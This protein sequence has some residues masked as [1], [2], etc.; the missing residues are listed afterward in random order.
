MI[1]KLSKIIFLFL[2]FFDFIL[3]KIF[4]K[5]FLVWFKDF[6]EQKSYK[7]VNLKKDKD[8][9]KLTFFTPNYLTTWLV[10]DFFRKEPETIEWIENFEKKNDKIIFWDVGANIGL[11]SI[12]AAKI[13]KSIEVISFEPSTNNLRV[14]SKNI[15]A[16]KLNSKIKIFQL[17]LSDQEFKF[18]EFKESQF[19]EGASHNCFY[20]DM[21]FEGKKINIKNN[22][23]IM[24]TSIRYILDNNILDV[25]DYIKIDVDGIEHLILKGAG[26]HLLNT[27]IKNIQIE[28]NEN[29]KEHFETVVDILSKNGFKLK[30][31]KRNESLKIYEDK[32]F[33]KTFNYYFYR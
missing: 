1:K 32:K 9:E 26:K 21:D 11:Y 31:K 30:T 23:N 8:N 17:P 2:N 15:F 27:R 19:N 25:P 16:N 6:Y 24:G 10:D 13:H 33:S 12:Y 3:V 4:K 7:T 20:Y 22:Y 28:I 18:A 29:F 14:L 5:S